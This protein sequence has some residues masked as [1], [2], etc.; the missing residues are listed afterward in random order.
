MIQKRTIEFEMKIQNAKYHMH[1]Q[2]I[3]QYYH[4]SDI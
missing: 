3:M 1:E 4:S 2:L